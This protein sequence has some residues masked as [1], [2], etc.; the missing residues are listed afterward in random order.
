[1]TVS[2]FGYVTVTADVTVAEDTTVTHDAALTTAPTGTVTGTVTSASGPEAEVTVKVQGTPVR[3]ETGADGRYTL[4]VPVGSYRFGVTPLNHCAAAVG[5]A[6]AVAKGAN[7]RNVA[8]A[9]RADVFGTT[10]RRD[11]GGVPGRGHAAHPQ[12]ADRL[13][14]PRHPPLPGRPVRAHLRQGLGDPRRAAGLRLAVHG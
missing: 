9:S 10:C 3:V 8:L 1:M 14:R 5:V 11:H 2:K 4:T 7:S 6:V 12:P 13:L